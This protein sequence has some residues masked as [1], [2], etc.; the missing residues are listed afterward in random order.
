MISVVKQYVDN[1]EIT[2]AKLNTALEDQDWETVGKIV[3][4]I[5]G[6]GG[7]FGF[8]QL[9]NLAKELDRLIKSKR[10]G[11]TKDLFQSLNKTYDRI[12]AA[13]F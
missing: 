3:H 10:Y 12:R 2:Q 13:R 4:D 5:K 9:S 8:P 7:A 6:S 1:L 11:A